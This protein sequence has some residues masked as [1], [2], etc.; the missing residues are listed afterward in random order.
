MRRPLLVLSL[1]VLLTAG[2]AFAQSSLLEGRWKLNVA[3][4]TYTP[5][6]PPK[7]QVLTWKRVPGG[8]QF[9]TETVSEEG[10]P[11][12]TDTFEKD[13]GSEGK[14]TGGSGNRTRFLRRLN[15]RTYEDG[16]TVNGAPTYRRRM[17]IAPDGRTMTI[18][19]TGVN[20]LGQPMNNTAVYDKQ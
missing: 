18:T 19:V 4:S 15:A 5:D 2:V 16:D 9:T 6:P 8:L 12:R 17:V 1:A 20:G 7:S 11:S 13:D 14:V 3:Q 10:Q